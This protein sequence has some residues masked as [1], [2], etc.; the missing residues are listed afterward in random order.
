MSDT[1][2]GIPEYVAESRG[3]T[4]WLL[5][6]VLAAA[7]FVGIGYLVYDADRNS[8]KPGHEYFRRQLASVKAGETNSIY[9]YD[10]R[11]TDGL[12]RAGRV[13]GGRGA[14]L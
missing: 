14:R 4:P 1:L 13:A 8:A 2:A 9:L 12:L 5:V 3:K 10:S 6:L 7:P 11:W